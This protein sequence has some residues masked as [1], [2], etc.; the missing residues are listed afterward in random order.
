MIESKGR[1]A[2]NQLSPEREEEL[3][4][5]ARQVFIEYGLGRATTDKI[6]EKARISKTTL[7]RRYHSKE[8][9][10]EAVIRRESDIMQ[11]ELQAFS[12]DVTAP[13][14]SLRGAARMIRAS[15][16]SPRHTEVRRLM[17][18]EA[19]RHPALIREARDLLYRAVAANLEPF[20]KELMASG[21]MRTV[22]IARAI[23]NF[24]LVFGGGLRPL[25]GVETN[26]AEDE[27]LLEEE[28]ELFLRGWGIVGN[29]P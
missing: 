14:A 26:P 5:T 21:K 9:L 13:A 2:P 27:A 19:P 8:A 28:V 17:I 20:L 3:L 6:V 10:F 22:N 15:A 1:R 16:G 18:A 4:D 29:D 11:R 7:Y 25:L 23:A 24:G 12:L